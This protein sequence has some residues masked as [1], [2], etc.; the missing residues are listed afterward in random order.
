L[1]CYCIELLL[2]WTITVLNYYCIELF[3]FLFLNCYCI[4]LLL[5]LFLN[6]YCFELLLYWT[7]IVFVFVFELLLSSKVVLWPLFRFLTISR[8][9]ELCFKRDWSRWKAKTRGYKSFEGRRTH[10]APK[11]VKIAHQIINPTTLQI[12]QSWPSLG[13]WPITGVLQIQ[14]EQDQFL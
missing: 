11:I 1:N 6:R 13:W 3:L 5:F 8:V 14:I 7:V 10:F 12:G 4:E 2:F 9:L